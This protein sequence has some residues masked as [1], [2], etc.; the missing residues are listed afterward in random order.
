MLALAVLQSVALFGLQGYLVQVELDLA[1]GLP[2]FDIVGLPDTAVREARE[3]VRAALRNTGFEFPARRITANLAPADLRKEGPSYDLALAVGILAAMKQVPLESAQRFVYLGELSLEGRVRGVWGVLPSVAAARRQGQSA[4]IV[5]LVNAREAALVE[6]AEVYPVTDLGEVVALLRGEKEL[7]PYRVD[8]EALFAEATDD[9]G[10]DWAEVKGQFYA[11]R[12]LEIAAAGGHNVL[13]LG[14]PGTGKTMLARR[15]PGILPP[16]SLE[17]A[18]EVTEIY[19]LA[20]LLPAQVSLITARPF[21]APH[22]TAS[23]AALV[24]GGRYPRPGE[25]SLAHHGVLFLDEFPEFTKESLEALRQPLEDGM[26]TVA[27][28]QAVLRFPARFMLLAAANPCPCGF[29]LEEG[30]CS[31]TARQIQRYRARLS[32]PLMDRLDIFV[33]VPRVPLEDLIGDGREAECSARVRERVH[34]AR[35][36]QQERFRDSGIF[37]NAAMSSSQVRRF[38]SLTRE[39][40]HLLGM[41]FRRLQLSARGYD[42]ILRVARTIADLEGS[43]ELHSAHVA[44]A[45]QY[46]E[47]KG[48]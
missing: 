9:G 33:E 16:L 48:V 34:R 30:K 27:R 37:C 35:L 5:P 36:C 22:H 40:R 42:R 29:L 2:A 43:E 13:L 47:E 31:C 24:G 38:C 41:A 18:L 17:E 45:L 39:A 28:A 19:S 25:V 20:G 11:K 32:G 44:E 12:S 21:R 8:R 7:V 46:R 6:G 3:R 14:S 23:T 10:P 26:V 4:F 15:V 1:P